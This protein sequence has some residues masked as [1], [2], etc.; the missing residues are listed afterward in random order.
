M[1]TFIS[2]LKRFIRR[3]T[4]WR[5]SNDFCVRWGRF[6]IFTLSFRLGDIVSFLDNLPWEQAS[7]RYREYCQYL[8]D[9]GLSAYKRSLIRD[10]YDMG[11]LE[12]DM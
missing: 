12:I 5:H 7:R 2:R 3:L 6:M 8:S 11:Y 10:Y 1:E 4:G 9:I